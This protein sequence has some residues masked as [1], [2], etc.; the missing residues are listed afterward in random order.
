V[1]RCRETSAG[2]R[3]TFRPV[4]LLRPALSRV[5]ARNPFVCSPVFPPVHTG[6][7]IVV[8]WAKPGGISLADARTGGKPRR[9]H[10]LMGRT[11][12]DETTSITAHHLPRALR[13][14]RCSDADGCMRRKLLWYTGRAFLPW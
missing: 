2:S 6:A 11:L 12:C 3:L 9:E 5:R 8:H 1:F 7:A 13:H 14:Q 4:R 10:L